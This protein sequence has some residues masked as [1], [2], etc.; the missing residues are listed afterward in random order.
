VT[1]QGVLNGRVFVKP[2]NELMP[3][4][5]I[6]EHFTHKPGANHPKALNI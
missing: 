3:Y 4:G 6:S 1:I 5:V 2:L